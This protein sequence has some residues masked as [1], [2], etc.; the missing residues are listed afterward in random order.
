VP[1]VLVDSYVVLGGDRNDL[2]RVCQI[3]ADNFSEGMM[4]EIDFWG[5][6]DDSIKS[7]IRQRIV[8][9]VAKKFDELTRDAAT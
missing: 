2:N 3:L 6:F 1:K 8:D 4:A 5:P 7:E 9:C